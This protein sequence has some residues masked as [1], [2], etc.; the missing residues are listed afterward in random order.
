MTAT[1]NLKSR[2]PKGA[3]SSLVET[4][5]VK[6]MSKA[7]QRVGRGVS[8]S[9][10]SLH[11]HPRAQKS[12]NSNRRDMEDV[13]LSLLDDEQQR[14]AD[15]GLPTDRPHARRSKHSFSAKDKRA[16]VLL[17]VLCEYLYFLR[18]LVLLISLRSYSRSTCEF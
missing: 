6:D 11:I 13:E 1:N 5:K 7:D 16:M 12:S 17:V 2:Q 15:V 9:L 18:A 4:G 3:D 14:Q 8:S 10:N